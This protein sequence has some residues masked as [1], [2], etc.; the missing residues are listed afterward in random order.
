MPPFAGLHRQ[1]SERLRLGFIGSLMV[2]K[3]PNLLLEAFAGLP[4]ERVS[5]TI[6]GD[7]VPYHGDDSYASRIRPLLAAADVRW[8]GG[9]KHDQVPSILAALDVLVVPS[10]WIE[11]APFVIKEAFAARV[12]VVASN[13]GGMAEMVPDGTSRLA[14][15]ARRLDRSPSCPDATAR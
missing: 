1:D 9:V 11:N 13:L 12:P 5:L 10:V 3:A 4:H 6:A 15:R 7:L 14:V 2:S 8:L